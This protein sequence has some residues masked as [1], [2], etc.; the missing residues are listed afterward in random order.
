MKTEHSKEVFAALRGAVEAE[1]FGAA[2][3]AL[4]SA[5][6][7]ASQMIDVEKA[8]DPSQYWRL[9]LDSITSTAPFVENDR[10]RQWFEKH[11][12]EG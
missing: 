2:A 3:A 10:M 1:D 9:A 7:N 11:G 4:D 6:R 5:E 8:A 12:F